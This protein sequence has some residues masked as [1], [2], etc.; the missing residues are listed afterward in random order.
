MT[1]T[2]SNSRM[3]LLLEKIAFYRKKKNYE[4]E[5]IKWQY[6]NTK[7]SLQPIN[8]LKN[9]FLERIATTNPKKNIMNIGIALATNFLSNRIRSNPSNNPIKNIIASVLKFLKN[10]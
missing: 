7:Q 8:L 6:Q 2:K 10:K 4:M 1:H 9:S 5:L 3:E